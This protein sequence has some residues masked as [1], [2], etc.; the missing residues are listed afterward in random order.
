MKISKHCHCFLQHPYT[1]KIDEQSHIECTYNSVTLPQG[2]GTSS[3]TESLDLKFEATSGSLAVKRVKL[4][5][6]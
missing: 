1:R 2:E 6:F 3:K 4:K 5:V